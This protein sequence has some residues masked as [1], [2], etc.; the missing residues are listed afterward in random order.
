MTEKY[1]DKNRIESLAGQIPPLPVQKKGESNQSYMERV[2][3][4]FTEVD[5]LTEKYQ[6][7]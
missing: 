6:N 1:D 7:G 3:E 2:N 5:K 4:Y